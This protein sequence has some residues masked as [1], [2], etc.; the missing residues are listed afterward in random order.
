MRNSNFYEASNTEN[1]ASSSSTHTGHIHNDTQAWGLIE[2]RSLTKHYLK[3][4]LG[5]H[6]F[7]T[8]NWLYTRDRA[9][10][11]VPKNNN[12]TA[13]TRNLVCFS[14][15]FQITS[16]HTTV[17]KSQPPTST[18]DSYFQIYLNTPQGCS[19]NINPFT[20]QSVLELRQRKWTVKHFIFFSLNVP[21]CAITN[22]L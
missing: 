17:S 4:R 22:L 18:H 14:L 12:F 2:A 8:Y 15:A 3:L 1:W 10:Y 11:C 5:N 9:Y 20:S 19:W 16:F 21:S 7:S 13:S 6:L